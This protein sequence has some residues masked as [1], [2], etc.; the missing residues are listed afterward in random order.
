M[1]RISLFK[2]LLATLL[3]VPPAAVH[4][5]DMKGT[6]GTYYNILYDSDTGKNIYFN[7][8]MTSE[9]TYKDENYNSYSGTIKATTYHISNANTYY[10]I[11]VGDKACYNCTDL[12]TVNFGT[13]SNISFIGDYAFFNCTSLSSIDLSEMPLDSLGVGAFESCSSLTEI[14]LSSSNLTSI[15]AYAFAWCENLTTIILP[16]TVR[17]IGEG[18]FEGCTSLRNIE[19]PSKLNYIEDYAFFGCSSLT[20]VTLGSYM[21]RI[22]TFAFAECST[23]MN[24]SIKSPNLISLGSFA[25]LSCPSLQSIDLS[26][27]IIETIGDGAFLSCGLLSTVVLPEWLETLGGVAFYDCQQLASINLGDTRVTSIGYSAFSYCS[28]LEAVDIPKTLTS[29]DEGVFAECTKLTSVTGLDKTTIPSIKDGVFYDCWAL[30]SLDVPSTLTNLGAYAF[31]GCHA[32]TAVN[33]LG[34]T[35]VTAIADYE[36][37]QCKSLQSIDIP[38]TVTSL[39]TNAFCQCSALTTVNGL[40]NTS[41]E[42]IPDYAFYQCSSL[43]SI[44]IPNSVTSV[45]EFALCDCTALTD[46]TISK[47]SKLT[48][49]GYFAFSGAPIETIT[50]PASLTSIEAEAFSECTELTS[51]YSYTATPAMCEGDDIFRKVPSTCVLYVPAGSEEAYGEFS[52]DYLDTWNS[53]SIIRTFH[54]LDVAAKADWDIKGNKEGYGYMTFYNGK[55]TYTLPE[56][57]I[58]T[59]VSGMDDDGNLIM[60][61]EYSGD[62][63]DNV[64]PANTAVILY[65]KLDEYMSM[66]DYKREKSKY[67]TIAEETAPETNWL[68]G[69]WDTD[70]LYTDT[71]YPDGVVFAYDGNDDKT[72]DGYWFYALN[73]T[74]IDSDGVYMNLGFYWG[75]EDGK[76]FW[77]AAKKAWLAVPKGSNNGAKFLG[78][79]SGTDNETTG[80]ETVFNETSLDD[81]VGDGYIYNLAGQ[82]VNDMSH[83]GIYIVDGKKV[84]KK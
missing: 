46:A 42:S 51:I 2:A 55:Y 29:I 58:A 8:W 70:E 37:Y 71:D 82:R 65:G 5:Y 32:L 4:A 81:S 77:L 47:D 72:I 34:N 54:L 3:L 78:F 41:I 61:W 27:T 84:V 26:S 45:G 48:S 17:D 75:A 21:V 74:N 23:L 36:F 16:S 33:G 76:P 50:L 39:G 52:S 35:K 7:G 38:S 43:T 22:G 14:D 62:G 80:I 13:P 28:K 53:L 67:G 24:V 60:N 25:F 69:V 18:A 56:G 40:G 79:T 11:G 30:E 15:P 73:Y 31:Y 12:T 66:V 68:Y 49:I 20:S 57:I 10:C 44:D 19:I 1:K 9:V 59:T 6:N 83:C 64:I 63:E